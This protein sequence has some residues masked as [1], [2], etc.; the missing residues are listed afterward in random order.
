MQEIAFPGFQGIIPPI[1]N[2]KLRLIFFFTFCAFFPSFISNT[3]I[4]SINFRAN[5]GAQNAGNGISV[6]Q[7]LIIFW[8]NTPPHT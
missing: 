7:I 6:L 2:D 3:T 1:S 8:G 4:V 5:L